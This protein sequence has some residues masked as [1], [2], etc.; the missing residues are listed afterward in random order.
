MA[1]LRL[2]A[3]DSWVNPVAKI[4]NVCILLMLPFLLMFLLLFLFFAIFLFL[5]V[6]LSTYC[7]G[8]SAW[9]Q[10]HL[11]FRHQNYGHLLQVDAP[12]L[13]EQILTP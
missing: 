1:V 8:R 13:I 12:G 9:M 5:V 7:P 4:L 3:S 10:P 11:R 6:Y 2:G